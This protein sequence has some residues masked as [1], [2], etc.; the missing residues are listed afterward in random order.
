[1]IAVAVIVADDAHA[2]PFQPLYFER[3]WKKFDLISR[4]LIVLLD[5]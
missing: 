5:I 4:Y 1:M 3:F 2:L